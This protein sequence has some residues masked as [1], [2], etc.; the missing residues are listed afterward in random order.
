M[1]L[2]PHSPAFAQPTW[3]TV[4]GPALGP[5]RRYLAA[6]RVCIGSMLLVLL[7]SLHLVLGAP[8]TLVSTLDAPEFVRDAGELLEI[9][10]SAFSC[11]SLGLGGEPTHLT[12][13]FNLNY[14]LPLAQITDAYPLTA[15]RSDHVPNPN[16]VAAA[17]DARSRMFY[18]W[19]GQKGS[20]LLTPVRRSGGITIVLGCKSLQVQLPNYIVTVASVL[21]DMDMHVIAEDPHAAYGDIGTPTFWLG[22]ESEAGNDLFQSL[23]VG[24]PPSPWRVGS[25]RIDPVSSGMPQSG[26]IGVNGS[27][28]KIAYGSTHYYQGPQESYPVPPPYGSLR[29]NLY[30]FASASPPLNDDFNVYAVAPGS[31]TYLKLDDTGWDFIPGSYLTV[32]P[33]YFSPAFLQLRQAKN[34]APCPILANGRAA[35]WYVNKYDDLF[36]ANADPT[37]R[38]RVIVGTYPD[39]YYVREVEVRSP[40]GVDYSYDRPN[41]A[42]LKSA[43]Y[44]FVIRY[45]GGGYRTD[46]TTGKRIGKQITGA[47]AREL[48]AAGLDIVLVF[49]GGAKR[50]LEG[51]SAG[52]DDAQTAVSQ[53]AGAGAPPDFFC[54]FACDFDAQPSDQTA[55]NA[56]LDGAASVLGV[57]RVG[58]YG[59]YGP[60]RSVLNAGKAAK[61][62]QTSSWSGDYVD[63][64]IC[65]Y[66]HADKPRIIAGG[67]CDVDDRYSNDIGQWV[68]PPLLSAVATPVFTPAGGTFKSALRVTITCATPGA[69]IRYETDGTDPTYFSPAYAGPITLSRSANVKAMASASGYSDSAFATASFTLPAPSLPNAPWGQTPNAVASSGFTLVPPAIT[70]VG[71]GP[72]LAPNTGIFQ[73]EVHSSQPR[74]T[75]QVSDDLVTW[76]NTPTLNVIG[77]SAYFTDPDV[78]KHSARY[79]RLKP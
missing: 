47:E 32:V 55:I 20:Y 5:S 34:D 67:A 51:Y 78:G 49:E 3:E 52:V 61:G 7:T 2:E 12:V 33:R 11:D 9:P 15:W 46:R 39:F 18:F 58:F 24:L 77:G 4:D 37:N 23:G 70:G 75:I 74:I 36:G 68:G 26:W 50:M 48:K 69:T 35:G 8:A 79:Y 44:N 38:L 19:A 57:S 31:T 16:V 71:G 6:L 64:R 72:I 30:P 76:T 73:I 10:E 21:M 28:D 1:L 59:G 27:S 13:G 25:F 60:L 45:L 53:A 41:P 29:V 22:Y 40:R 65:L 66:Q 43:G 14:Y 56:Y 42:G 62:W 17:F 54:Y 63:L